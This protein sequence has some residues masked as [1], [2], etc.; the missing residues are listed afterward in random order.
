MDNYMNI[1]CKATIENEKN[2][3]YLVSLFIAQA[4]PTLNEITEV[5]TLMSEAVANAVI[6][7]YQNKQEGD[8]EIDLIIEQKKLRMRIK[9]TG[10]GIPDINQALQPLYTSKPELERSGM[11]MTI[12]KSLSDEF[13]VVSEIN[14]GTEIKITKTFRG[15]K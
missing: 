8:I 3:R 6:H 15:A 12:M 11:G 5:K 14:K 7:A 10:C 1:I 2:M 4:N 13:E 9:D